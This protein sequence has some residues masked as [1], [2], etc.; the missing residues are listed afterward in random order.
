[1]YIQYP[2]LIG[3]TNKKGYEFCK[4]VYIDETGIS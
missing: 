4:T 2:F 1:M 3:F